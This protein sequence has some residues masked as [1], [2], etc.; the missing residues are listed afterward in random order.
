MKIEKMKM[1]KMTCRPPTNMYYAVFNSYSIPLHCQGYLQ[2]S[3]WGHLLRQMA[4]EHAARSRY[5]RVPGWTPLPW[6]LEGRE[7]T[8]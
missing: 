6:R 8:W 3:R 4:K 1:I 5:L 2:V 7:E